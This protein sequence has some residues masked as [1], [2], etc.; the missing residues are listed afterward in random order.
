MSCNKERRKNTL[1][2]ASQRRAS[3]RALVRNEGEPLIVKPSAVPAPKS[4]T[5][6]RDASISS[7]LVHCTLQAELSSLLIILWVTRNLHM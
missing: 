7:V 2:C 6:K 5:K 3:L 1:A 4:G